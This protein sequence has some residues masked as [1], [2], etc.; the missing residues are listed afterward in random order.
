MSILS[1]VCVQHR[2]EK[3]N[4]N[5]SYNNNESKKKKN[6]NQQNKNRIERSNITHFQQSKSRVMMFLFPQSQHRR[7]SRRKIRKMRFCWI[8]S[9]VEMRQQWNSGATLNEMHIIFT[10]KKKKNYKQNVEKKNSIKCLLRIF[11]KISFQNYVFNLKNLHSKC[12][13]RGR[14]WLPRTFSFNPSISSLSWCCTNDEK[15]VKQIE[16]K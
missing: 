10:S 12:L 14:A 1:V 5:I 6:S 15:K 9:F 2:C 3:W 8:N 7:R 4:Q 13:E 11:T 16:M